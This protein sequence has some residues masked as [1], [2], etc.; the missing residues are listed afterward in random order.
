MEKSELIEWIVIIACVVSWWPRIFLGYDPLWYHVLIYYAAPVALVAI[1]VRRI[2]RMRAGLEYSE[3][4][5]QS[6][7]GGRPLPDLT[8]R[9][10]K[11]KG[12]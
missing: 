3:K 4:A 9:E 10:G 7:R 1:L 2:R 8:E 5:V 12:R 6:Q 11:K